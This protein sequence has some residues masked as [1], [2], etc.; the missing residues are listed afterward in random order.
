MGIL[1]VFSHSSPMY[2][3]AIVGAGPSGIGVAAI[4]KDL[5]CENYIIL[6][7]HQPGY[8]FTKWPEETKLITPSFTTNF[9]GQMDLNAVVQ[10]TS[11]A[12]SLGM[13]HPSGRD[14][15]RYLNL[16]VEHLDLPIR[17]PFDVSAV[18]GEG[19]Y[20]RIKAQDGSSIDAKYVVWAAGEFQYPRE[21]SFLGAEHCRH[22]A[23][24][25][26]FSDYSGKNAVVIG[27]YESGIDAA[28]HLS[29]QGKT[30]KVIGKTPFWTINT[31]D[32]SNNLSPFTRERLTEEMAKGRIELI[33]DTRVVEVEFADG[34]Y[35]IHTD[36]SSIAIESPAQPI[37]ATGFLSSLSVVREHFAFPEDDWIPSLTQ[38]DESVIAPGLF[39][40]GP[41]VRHDSIIFCFIYKFRQRFGVVARALG[42]RLGLDTTKTE[43]YRQEGLLMD[44]LSCC[45]QEC[46]C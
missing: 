6:E 20:F 9:Y 43:K 30:V 29:R 8:S 28:I 46:S 13:E 17:A 32:P 2:D 3:V 21:D 5:G 35:R 19:G 10:G 37:L 26:R 22:Y 7:R 39:L 42:H 15:A 31:T 18:E 12:Y 23:H 38:E 27:G 24:I 4:L 40:V 33:G 34:I 14:Y 25:E 44:D 16:A 45:S 1:N 41:Q 11:P 36:A